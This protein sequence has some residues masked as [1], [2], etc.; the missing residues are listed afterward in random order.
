[1]NEDRPSQPVETPEQRMEQLLRDLREANERL[2]IAG[3]RLQELAE[4]ADKE[5]RLADA[6]RRQAESSRIAAQNASHSKDEFLAVL[7]HE[8]RT[9][10]N[11]ILGWTR[12][13]RGGG[14]RGVNSDHALDII[15]RN[16]YLQ[17]Q[18]INDLLQLSQITSGNLRLDMKSV[19]LVPIVMISIDTLRPTAL[20]KEITLESEIKAG[21]GGVLADP[22]RLQQIIWNLLSNA[23]KFTPRGGR[24]IVGLNQIGSTA[25][26]TVAD[27]GIGMEPE[28]LPYVFDRFRQADSSSARK[29]GGLGLGL[30]IVRQL[31]ELHGGNVMVKSPGKGLGSTFTVTF[32]IRAVIGHPEESKR[33]GANQTLQGL[34]L[35]VVEDDPDSLELMTTILEA[36]GA[37]VTAVGEAQEALAA[38][39][40]WKPHALIAD[41]GLPDLDG[42][43]LISQIRACKT[44]TSD[45]L[46]AIALT[47]YIMPE[48]RNRALASGFDLYIT[49]PVEEDELISAIARIARR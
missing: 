39:D 40:D 24:V 20:A 33:I 9:P 36:R 35:L 46:P 16:A 41:I 31:V 23:I 29:Y 19:D 45:R 26:I 7:S 47:A 3:V 44:T 15:E 21:V 18:L 38:L 37:V 43:A 48:D 32:P 17:L 14:L 34:R 10:L 27:S 30:A 4:E 6:A 2:V 49:K 25:Q 42:Y 5:R 22:A 12:L 11:S 1:M 13:L 8:L 28:F